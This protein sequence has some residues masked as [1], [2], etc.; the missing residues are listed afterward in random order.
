[1]A[2]DGVVLTGDTL[3][4][5]GPGATRFPYSSFPTIIESIED[6]LMTLPDATVVLPGPRCSDDDRIGAPT[7][8]GMDRTRL[9]NKELPWN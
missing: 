5:G 1:M 6:S 4:P 2:L 3:F 9:V 7:A 8:A